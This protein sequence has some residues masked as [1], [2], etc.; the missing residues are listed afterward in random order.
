MDSTVTRNTF[1][2]TNSKRNRY[3]FNLDAKTFPGKILKRN[4]TERDGAYLRQR[5]LKSVCRISFPVFIQITISM[6]AIERL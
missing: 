2:E 4:M 5:G 1:P 3:G 6:D